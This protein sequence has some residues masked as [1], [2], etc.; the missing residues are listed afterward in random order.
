MIEIR[1]EYIGLLGKPR[2]IVL[3][4]EEYKTLIDATRFASGQ[5]PQMEFRCKV[6]KI[7]S[8]LIKLP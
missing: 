4:K 5:H 7:I 8:K 6:G 2:P 1:S 3:T